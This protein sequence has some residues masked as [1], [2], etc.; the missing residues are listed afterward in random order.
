MVLHERFDEDV[1]LEDALFVR[2]TET[3]RMVSLLDGV[4][5]VLLDLFGGFVSRIR[6]LRFG[7]SVD[8]GAR[9]DGT[10]SVISSG[11]LVGDTVHVLTHSFVSLLERHLQE[12]Q[13][14][15]LPLLL[16]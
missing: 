9:S 4:P 15:L 7:R 14:F 16:C 1:R 10:L 11:P 8:N 2:K 13:W 3:V 5:R 12:V 6:R